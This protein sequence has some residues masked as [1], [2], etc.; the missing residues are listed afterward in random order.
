ME[1]WKTEIFQDQALNKLFDQDLTQ[2]EFMLL[3]LKNCIHNIPTSR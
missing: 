1:K 2:E 3:I